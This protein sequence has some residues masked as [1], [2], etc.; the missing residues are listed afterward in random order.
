MGIAPPG[1]LCGLMESGLSVS[2]KETHGRQPIEYRD[3]CEIIEYITSMDCGFK[4]TQSHFFMF[5][6]LDKNSQA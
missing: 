3:Q 4:E 1:L 6:N 5:E 2:I